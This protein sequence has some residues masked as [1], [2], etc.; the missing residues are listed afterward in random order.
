MSQPSAALSSKHEQPRG[1]GL[2][3]MLGGSLWLLFYGASALAGRELGEGPRDVNDSGL[4]RLGAAAFSGALL[5]LGIGLM[6]LK[7]RLQGRA[8]RLGLA[9]TVMAALAIALGTV[10]VLML[11]GL[12]GPPRF[13]GGLAALGVLGVCT[14]AVLLGLATRREQVLPRWGSTLLAVTGPLT[15]VLIAT[16]GLRFGSIPGYVLDDLPF[17]IAGLLWITAGVAMRS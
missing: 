6:G 3:A 1:E 11:T 8:P 7:A 14:G 12:L 10:N 17:A 4:L 15:V 13:I 2:A 16:S 5:A 9:S